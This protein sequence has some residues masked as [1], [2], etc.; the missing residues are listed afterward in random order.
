MIVRGLGVFVKVRPASEFG[1][2]LGV[3]EAASSVAI[4]VAG[5]RNRKSLPL[6]HVA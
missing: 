1:G 2:L 4:W 6:F 5:S 3:R